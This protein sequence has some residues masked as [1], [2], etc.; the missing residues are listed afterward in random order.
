VDVSSIWE[1][2]LAA[3]RCHATQLSS[4]PMMRAS[5]ERQRLFF[6]REYFVRALCRRSETDFMAEALKDDLL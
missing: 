3:M 5:A 2:K 6:G 4:S 1:T